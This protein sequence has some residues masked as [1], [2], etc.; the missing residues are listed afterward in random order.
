[1]DSDKLPHFDILD[2]TIR[3][4]GYLNNWRFDAKM[5]R[6]VYRALSKAGVDIVEIGFRGTDKYFNRNEFGPW[7]FT[8][9]KDLKEVVGG[10][11]GARLAIMGDYGK[12]DV[13][14][15]TDDYREYVDF[16]RIAVHKDG[17]P[18]AI[19]QLEEIKKKGFEVSLNA[20]G[21][22]GYTGEETQ[23]LVKMLADSDIDY[24]YIADSYGSI[25]PDQM[26]QL[27]EPFLG[28]KH[29]K[30]GFHPHNSLQMAF[31][32]TLEAI[33]CGVD[34]IDGTIYGM[35]RGAGNLPTEVILSYLQLSTTDKYNVIPILHCID[36]FFTNIQ[37]DE[38][39]GYQLPYMLSGIFQCHPYYPKT[40]VDYREFS[41]E[42]IWKAL[43]VLRKI[44]PVGFS[45]DILDDIIKSGMIGGLRKGKIGEGKSVD[46][47]KQ[48]E[49]TIEVPYKDLYKGRDFLLLA[50]GPTL[51]EY[52]TKI[53]EFIKKYNP[54][55][56]GA[57]YLSGLFKPHYHSFNNK[58]RFVDYI[59]TV[60]NNAVLLLGENFP[61]DMIREYTSRSYETL[62]FNDELN[63]FDIIDGVI[64]SNCRTIAVLL[65][66]V[67]I[68]MGANRIFAVG[69]D[70][71]AGS[72]L[73]EGFHFYDEKVEPE[74]KDLVIERHRYN[75]HFIEQIDEYLNSI[76]K[77]GIHI[78]TP[79][80]YKAFYKGIENYL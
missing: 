69:M 44:N 17:T 60:D 73:K 64:Q 11:K 71:Y 35:G 3:D 15:F 14:D 48:R 66:G 59:D 37:T 12:L 21:I 24:I 28:L 65:M 62:Y 25:L 43:E 33:K 76:G 63:D 13:E 51:K 47:N 6:E 70:G 52:G 18:G 1:M 42:D 22:T 45:K 5:V 27:V 72:E 23:E 74:E 41:M 7:R 75:Q 61:D 40:L 79:T 57:N 9:I 29:I 16:I 26:R 55:I 10:I 46:A 78:L 50:N 4:G 80:S 19:R 54:V 36:R 68:V 34:I 32:N 56:L 20:M 38:P 39:W 2:C 8:D 67:A 77:E 49:R 30:I 31:A 58:K 53:D